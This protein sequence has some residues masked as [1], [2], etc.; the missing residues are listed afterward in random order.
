ME[1][2]IASGAALPVDLQLRWLYE[3]DCLH[4]LV[5]RPTDLWFD[6]EGA[7]AAGPPPGGNGVFQAT[8]EIGG[9]CRKS[10]SPALCALMLQLGE[11][12]VLKDGVDRNSAKPSDWTPPARAIDPADELPPLY[13]VDANGRTAIPDA[14]LSALADRLAL[15]RTRAARHPRS[16]RGDCSAVESIPAKEIA[17]VL[18]QIRQWQTAALADPTMP[19]RDPRTGYVP[20]DPGFIEMCSQASRYE[21]TCRQRGD[22]MSSAPANAT[23]PSASAGQTAAFDDC[24]NL[25]GSVVAMCQG[26][27]WREEPSPLFAGMSPQCQTLTQAYLDAAAA[28][29]NAAALVGFG[30]LKTTC[31]DAVE[32]LAHKVGAAAP[33]EAASLPPGVLS[34]PGGAGTLSSDVFG[35]CSRSP[36]P[37]ECADAP[38]DAFQGSLYN[39]A[40]VLGFAAQ[41]MSVA[42]NAAAL[43]AAMSA[44]GPV[45]GSNMN[46][47]AAPI[48]RSA[49]GRGSPV[50]RP[51]P[52][53]HQSTITGPIH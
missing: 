18:S 29:D 25:Y 6:A 12:Q 28:K 19:S 21:A 24:A 1:D 49:P 44:G 40:E 30:A 22:A 53:S 42:G 31:P 5:A 27:G 38:S 14:C 47:L 46:S 39:L 32:E 15:P 50:F 10:S 3:K 7:P 52:P 13:L 45:R 33:A 11:G 4:S 20:K 35:R 43:G 26:A 2:K 41:V 23:P 36:A 8:E 51:P 9:Y 34:R 37:P 17:N 16:R 48:I